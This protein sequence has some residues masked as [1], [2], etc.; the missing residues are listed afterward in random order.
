MEDIEKYFIDFVKKECK[1][2]GVKCRLKNTS[3]VIINKT[4]KVSG[5]FD[6]S[7][8][9]LV[10]SMNSKESI[11]IL[12]HEYCHLTQW[13]DYIPLWKKAEISIPIVF[14]WLDGKNVRNIKQHLAVCRDLEL[15]NEKRSVEMIKKHNLPIDIKRY[16]KRANA[17]VQFYNYLYISRKWSNSKNTPYNNENLINIMP[18]KFNMRYSKMSKKV[19]KMF[20]QENI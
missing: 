13:I 9:E 20:I 1:K 17:Y 8:P 14:N 4:T 15:D 5:Y 11:S 19:E 16:I 12:V 2:Y 18:D 3:Y 6:E 10:C 7:V